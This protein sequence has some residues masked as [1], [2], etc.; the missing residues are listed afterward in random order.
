MQPDLFVSNTQQRKK[1][2]RKSD[3]TTKTTLEIIGGVL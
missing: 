3:C 2:E 1:Q